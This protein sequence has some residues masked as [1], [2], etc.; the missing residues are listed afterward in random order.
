VNFKL[1][2]SGYNSGTQRIAGRLGSTAGVDGFGD[3]KNLLPQAELEIRFFKPVVYSHFGMNV[4]TV[5]Q[6]L[7]HYATNRQ[8]AGSI[9][10]GVPGI[11]Q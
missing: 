1:Y 9:P 2:A 3:E 8:V 4:R 6:W 5:A 11:F 10:D 7:R